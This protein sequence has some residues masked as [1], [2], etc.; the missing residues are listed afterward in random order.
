M[1]NDVMSLNNT[2]DKLTNGRRT[3]ITLLHCN[4]KTVEKE[5]E[6]TVKEEKETS[7]KEENEVVQWVH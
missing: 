4:P 6:E 5:K 1:D 2:Y 7:F 3:I